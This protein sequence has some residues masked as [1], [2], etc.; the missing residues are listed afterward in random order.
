LLAGS[1]V[2]IARQVTPSLGGNCS[3]EKQKSSSLQSQF[4]ATACKGFSSGGERGP[5]WPGQNTRQQS[6]S[7]RKRAAK[8]AVPALLKKLAIRMGGGVQP[9]C[10]RKGEIIR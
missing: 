7:V 8:K 4:W 3:F 1:W 6:R 9:G 10:V 2:V 5:V